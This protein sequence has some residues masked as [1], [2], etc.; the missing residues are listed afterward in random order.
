MRAMLFQLLLREVSNGH[1][2]EEPSVS[3]SLGLVLSNDTVLGPGVVLEGVD[4]VVLVW[5]VFEM[6]PL[7]GL[8]VLQPLVLFEF[9]PQDFLIRILH[10]ILE[11]EFV[12]FSHL[13]LHSLRFFFLLVSVDLIKFHF[14][15]IV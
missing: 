8:E 11:L 12:F 5:Q 2:D 3:E 1:G 14:L 6:V 13:H 15:F 7:T 4:P 9:F 10:F